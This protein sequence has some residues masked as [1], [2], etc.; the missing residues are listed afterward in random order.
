M[1]NVQIG[2]PQ[3]RSGPLD[4][5]PNDDQEHPRS[6]SGFKH[7]LRTPRRHRAGCVSVRM[8]SPQDAASR[9]VL[10]ISNAGDNKFNHL[11]VRNELTK[12]RVAVLCVGGHLTAN[13][14]RGCA[15]PRVARQLP[16]S[17]E[18]S[19]KRAIPQAECLSSR[20]SV[21]GGVG[22]HGRSQ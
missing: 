21:E 14:G 17:V 4:V 8:L 13:L 3:D 2:P 7:T 15:S 19:W 12:G 20:G 6:R 5:G 18:E 9:R 16:Q 11:Q 1:N 22:N 10:T